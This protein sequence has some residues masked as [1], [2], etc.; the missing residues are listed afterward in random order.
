MTTPLHP[1][2]TSLSF[3]LGTWKGT[4]Q[5]QYPSIEDF[6]YEE[7]ISFSHIGKPFLIYT[8]RSWDPQSHNG[9]HIESG[10]LRP[11]GNDKAELVL[12][13]PSGI[14]EIHSGIINSKKVEFSSLQVGCSPS[15]KQ[16]SSV[17]R[18]LKVTEEILDCQLAMGAAGYPLLPHLHS[19]LTLT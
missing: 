9:L 1:S 11:S 4:G 13:Q 15:A 16:V 14:V 8:Q 2:L 5:G 17:K 7:K 12:S 6:R 3:L 10:Y 18:V 19:K